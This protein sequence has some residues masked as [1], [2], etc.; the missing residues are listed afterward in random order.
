MCWVAWSRLESKQAFFI[1]RL[2][3][4]Y[5]FKKTGRDQKM[6]LDKKTEMKY[7]FENWQSEKLL[8]DTWK[9]RQT[10]TQ[11]LLFFLFCKFFP[12]SIWVCTINYRFSYLH[13]WSPLQQCKDRCP[14]KDMH[15]ETSGAV[16]LL[17]KAGPFCLL[18]YMANF[19]DLRSPAV[20]TSSLPKTGQK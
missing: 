11:F 12:S 2:C 9:D 4:Q 13:G 19:F 15:R 14:G 5:L 8:K 16:T 6:K 17:G 18:Y 1:K 3:S 10:V 20:L 7:V